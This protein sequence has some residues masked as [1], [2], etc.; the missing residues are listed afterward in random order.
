MQAHA[1]RYGG[2]Q[3]EQILFGGSTPLLGTH[4][5]RVFEA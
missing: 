5:R 1:A 4:K 3:A 2:Q